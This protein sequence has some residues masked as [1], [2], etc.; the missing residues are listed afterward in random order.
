MTA[1]A[2]DKSLAPV[3]ARSQRL[4]GELE[5][6]KLEERIAH[7]EKR[8]NEECAKKE[9]NFDTIIDML[10][11]LALTERKYEQFKLVIEELFP[12]E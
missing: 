8:I 10:D 12:T 9:L 11:D 7:L 2:I 1:E 5:V 4:K 3:R 6:A